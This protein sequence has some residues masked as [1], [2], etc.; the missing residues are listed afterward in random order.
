MEQVSIQIPASLYAALYNRFGERTTAVIVGWLA[1]KAGA[2]DNSDS[3]QASSRSRYPRPQPGTKTGRVWQIADQIQEET[4]QASREAVIR[5]C[6]EEGLNVN[7]AST[8]YSYWNSS[9]S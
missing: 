7:T 5:A 6:L 8:Q 1:E 9:Q 3:T 2:T 4:G